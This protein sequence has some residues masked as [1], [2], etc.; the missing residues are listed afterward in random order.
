MGFVRTLS[1]SMPRD[2]AEAIKPGN[3]AYTALVPGRKFVTQAQSGLIQTGLWRT[4]NASGVVNFVIHTEWSTIE[5]MQ[6]YANHP[7]IKEI[8]QILGSDNNPVQI[9]VYEVIG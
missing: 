8:E 6:A 7:V 4:T 1:F 2:E 3:P 5:D 9:S